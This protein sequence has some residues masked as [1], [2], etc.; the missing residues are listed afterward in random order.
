MQ[1]CVCVCVC[2]YDVEDWNAGDRGMMMSG[3]SEEL[4]EVVEVERRLTVKCR[5]E[6]GDLNEW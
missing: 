3:G 5:C 2:V 1:Q 6:V 4:N